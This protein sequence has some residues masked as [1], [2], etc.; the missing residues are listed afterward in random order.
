[1]KQMGATSRI[2][3]A[4][5]ALGF[6]AAAL[7]REAP[8]GGATKDLVPFGAADGTMGRAHGG[9]IQYRDS[10]PD[11]PSG[12]NPIHNRYPPSYQGYGSVTVDGVLRASTAPPAPSSDP[13]IHENTP[14]S[15][16]A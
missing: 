13:S 3:L 9:D 16:H 1:M 2:L 11:V 14:P 5:A 6:V 7:A 4:I 12:E 8:G 15:D 10:K